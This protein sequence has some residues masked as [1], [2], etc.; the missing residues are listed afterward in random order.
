MSKGAHDSDSRV[1]RTRLAGI[2][3]RGEFDPRGGAN[4]HPPSS[5]VEAEEDGSKP[6]LV[7]IQFWSR[8]P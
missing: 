7:G 4:L 6:R 5:Q 1:F 2:G 8:T 3:A